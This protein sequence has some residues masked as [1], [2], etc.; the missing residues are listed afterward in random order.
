[1]VTGGNMAG[2]Q[3]DRWIQNRIAERQ[4]WDA[5][6]GQVL[7]EEERYDKEAGQRSKTRIGE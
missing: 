3:G 1:M 2:K 7:R 5:V 4:S 6:K